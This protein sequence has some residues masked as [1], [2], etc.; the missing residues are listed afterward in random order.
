MFKMS[1]PR[2]IG[3]RQFFFEKKRMA[4]LMANFLRFFSSLF[5]PHFFVCI[6]LN[7]SHLVLKCTYIICDIMDSSNM[8]NVHQPKA[9]IA[10][11]GQVRSLLI[12]LSKF[13]IH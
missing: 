1:H 3:G 10:P 7:L 8:S 2:L 5:F 11:Q 9:K 12:L 13:K 4:N 6:T